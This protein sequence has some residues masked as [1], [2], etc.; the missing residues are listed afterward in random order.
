[1]KDKRFIAVVIVLVLV[2]AGLFLLIN[3][4]N[5]SNKQ[6]P[7]RKVSTLPR[8]II[9]SVTLDKNGFTPASITIKKGETVSWLNK[10][11]VD[12]T[13]NSTPYPKNNSYPF[14]NLGSFKNGSTVQALFENPGT[15]TYYNYFVPAQKGT[16]IVK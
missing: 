13:V 9:K 5:N 6:T 4:K 2:A 3:S 14:L 15:F 11:G 16:V 10:S 1:M 8:A 12:A 7:V